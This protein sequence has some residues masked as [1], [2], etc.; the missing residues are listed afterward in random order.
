MRVTLHC[1]NEAT[2]EWLLASNPN[3]GW[4]TDPQCWEVE[5]DHTEDWGSPVGGVEPCDTNGD[6]IAIAA[7]NTL[8]IAYFE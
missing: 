1:Y 8:E 4:T 6:R 5:C 3:C 7:V 2:G